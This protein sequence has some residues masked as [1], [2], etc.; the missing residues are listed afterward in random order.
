MDEEPESGLMRR[1]AVARFAHE[2]NSFASIKASIKD[3]RDFE[4][5]AG[6]E[7]VPFY[8]RTATEIGGVIDALERYPEWRPT[9]LRCAFAT[10]SGEMLRDAFE[11]ILGEI[12]EGLAGTQWDAVF[13]AQHG[14]MQVEGIDHADLAIL[15]RVR[16]VIGDTPLGASYDLHANITPSQLDLLDIAIG[17]KCHP[18]TDMAETAAK[19]VEELIGYATSRRRPVFAYRRLPSFI[20]SVNARTTDGPMAEA[21]A[22]ARGVARRPEVIDVSIYQGYAY[23][24]RSHAGGS[25][26]VYA[27]HGQEDVAA[28]T[29]DSV[30][31]ETLRIYPRL[32]VAMPDAREGVAEALRRIDSGNGPV[33]VIDTADHPGA[34]ANADTPG[35]LRA[36]LDQVRGRDVVFAFF[37]DPETIAR[38]ESAGAGATIDVELGARLTSAFGPKIPVRARVERITDGRI[39]QVGPFQKG[40]TY[41]YGRTCMLSVESVRI[42]LTAKCLTVSDPAF[43]QLHGIDLGAVDLLAVKAKNQFRAAFAHSFASLIDIDEPGPAAYD[44]SRL[45]FRNVPPERR[46]MAEPR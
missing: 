10:P 46:R 34:G 25:V 2:G 30:L 15:Q 13:L 17:Y 37:W 14:A 4:W 24:D 45:P 33:A 21:M 43:F 29:A 12:L 19:A 9:Y 20:P 26:L 18:H 42:I 5:A 3:F 38:A 32:F 39:V 44:F 36:V 8:K 28:A 6:E 40:L 41:D 23:G 1:I 11:E 22:Y 27:D 7:V 31:A 16:A 35:M